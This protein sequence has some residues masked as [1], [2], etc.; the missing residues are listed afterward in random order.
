MFPSQSPS[1]RVI[2][3]SSSCWYSRRRYRQQS[4]QI[5]FAPASMLCSAS[6]LSMPAPT[7]ALQ[8]SRGGMVSFMAKRI[9]S[10]KGDPAF[11]Q[12]FVDQ[13]PNYL[14]VAFPGGFPLHATTTFIN[15]SG[16]SSSLIFIR[17]DGWRRE[18]TPT[19]DPSPS[20]WT[21]GREQT[22]SAEP[23]MTTEFSPPGGEG[24]STTETPLSAPELVFSTVEETNSSLP[25]LPPPPPPLA[26]N[27][28][29][30]PSLHRGSGRSCERT[31]A[32]FSPCTVEGT[33]STA[34][35]EP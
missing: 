8:T 16:S 10:G 5:R 32:E 21:A 30:F 34:S 33:N 35:S 4:N 25:P 19:I 15:D 31:G 1:F 11:C 29:R 3:P 14:H 22:N 20:G 27:R 7:A 26:S 23:P 24:S 2:F 18:L 13:T 12:G 17:L 6:S 9:A 28:V